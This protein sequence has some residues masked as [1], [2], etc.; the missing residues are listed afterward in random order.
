MHIPPFVKIHEN[1]S[2]IKSHISLGG[3][4][5]KGNSSKPVCISDTS[6]KRKQIGITIQNRGELINYR[7]KTSEQHAMIHC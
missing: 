6:I 4:I 3:H 7:K 1:G 2:D 5:N